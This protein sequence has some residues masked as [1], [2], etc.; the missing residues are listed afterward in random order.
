MSTW[1]EIS[2]EEFEGKIKT[3][4]DYEAEIATKFATFKAL[5]DTPVDSDGKPTGNA[6]IHDWPEE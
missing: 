5:F 4:A 1:K 3:S 6:P 2:R